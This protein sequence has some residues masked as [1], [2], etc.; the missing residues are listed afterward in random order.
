MNSEARYTGGWTPQK[1]AEFLIADTNFREWRITDFGP[2]WIDNDGKAFD[3]MD[4]DDS[5]FLATW[6]FVADRGTVT[7]AEILAE[8]PEVALRPAES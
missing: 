7:R 3:M 8:F 2:D 5:R 1:V 6:R 4:D